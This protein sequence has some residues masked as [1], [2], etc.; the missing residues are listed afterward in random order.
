MSGRYDV[1]GCQITPANLRSALDA[2]I[3]RV[4]SGKGGY[5]CFTNVHASVMAR[6]DLS[7]QRIVN[8]SF[9]SL[10]DG[11]PIYWVGRLRGVR[12][13]N[14][15]SGPD[16]LSALF[17]EESHSTIKHFFYGSRPETL[18]QLV[19]RLKE[20]FPDAIIVGKEAPAF[21]DLSAEE[22]QE[23]RQQIRK[24]GANVVW[25]GLRAPKQERWMADNWRQLKPAILLG[26][27]AA[28]DVHAGA[29]T[30]APVWMQNYGLEWLFRLLQE[31]G[32]LWKRYSYTNTM[33]LWYLISDFLNRRSA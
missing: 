27:G 22:T 14:R 2:V 33:F 3:E 8:N 30:R 4:Q 5:V 13:L 10:P 23:V 6:Q 1:I 20:M 18:A 29:V 26:V 16:F 17:A 31:P 25:V 9:M 24:S 28:F 7:Y 21:R 15:V 12:N 19:Q 32:R 11:K